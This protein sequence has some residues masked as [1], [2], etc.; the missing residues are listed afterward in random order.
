VKKSSIVIS[1]VTFLVIVACVVHIWG[2][3]ES[4]EVT[5]GSVDA[6]PEKETRPAGRVT[7]AVVGAE[8]LQARL[9][10]AIVTDETNPTVRIEVAGPQWLLPAGRFRLA[11]GRISYGVHDGNEWTANFCAGFAFTVYGDRPTQIELG[12]PTLSLG[13]RDSDGPKNNVQEK[14]VFARGVKLCLTPRVQG[15]GGEIYSGFWRREAAS[16]RMVP[17]NQHVAVLGSGDK[18]L[19]SEDVHW[20]Y[21]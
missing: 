19:W 1:V 6:V 12:S 2:P 21:G 18:P 14:P 5:R 4:A 17:V 8:P 10:S 13:V 15:R 3:R 11:E 7:I 16:G 20:G 9:T